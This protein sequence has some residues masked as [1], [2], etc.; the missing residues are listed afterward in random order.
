M[1]L[2]VAALLAGCSAGIFSNST[3]TTQ[4][5]PGAYLV[6][7][8]QRA[9]AAATRA[10]GVRLPTVTGAP[11]P[12][13]GSGAFANPLPAHQVLGFLPYWEVGSFSP[14]Y[15][16]LTTV[17]YFALTVGSGGTIS[18]A[19]YGWSTLHDRALV[20][21]VTTAHRA[22]DRV[23]LTVFSDTDSVLHSFAAAPQRASAVLASQLVPLL[24][25][26]GF[27]GV[28]LDL[29]G[30][31]GADRAGFTT[32]VGALS[33][34]LR[35]ADPTWS[36]VL[37]TYTTSAF[38]PAG[39]FDVKAL[40][41]YVDEFFVMAYEMQ[42]PSVPSPTAPLANSPQSDAVAVAEY[43]AVVPP[44]K[45]LLGIPLYGYD[46]PTRTTGSSEYLTGPPVAVTYSD[47]VSA[48]HAAKWDPLTDTAWTRFRR[49]TTWHV[50]YFDDP[51]SIA[52]KTALAS[53]F[54][55]AGVG[56]WELGMS[57]GDP[58]I[59]AALLGGSPPVKLSL[60]GPS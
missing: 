1:T 18:H 59:T 41:R 48:G 24:K 17:A 35:T 44:S 14:D 13:L 5:D 47:V 52:L 37:N 28:D 60:A 57:G 34:R 55:C 8:E 38:D 25:S 6:P 43:A 15:S 51:V 23:L 36:I 46:Y 56:V 50:T 20:S 21:D 54:R 30:T 2:L 11:A 49:G 3:A 22:R 31:N 53:E 42:D 4:P 40:A 33:A 39:F 10:V 16:R 7:R 45:V 9:V 12:V 32:F 19:G 29:E 27:D 58:S 26:L